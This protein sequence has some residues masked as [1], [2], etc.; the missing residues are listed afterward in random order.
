VVR[1]DVDEIE[2]KK[3]GHDEFSELSRMFA[4]IA[5][6]LLVDLRVKALREEIDAAS[7]L[8]LAPVDVTLA[9]QLE[10]VIGPVA[11]GGSTEGQN[12]ALPSVRAFFCYL[13]TP[14]RERMRVADV[15]G[16]RWRFLL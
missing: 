16:S 2:K 9:L 11:P 13:N 4:A 6:V 8:I 15:T 3:P 14:Q 10:E 1:V 12:N 7:A 5:E